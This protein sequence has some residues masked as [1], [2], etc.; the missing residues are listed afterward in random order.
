MQRLGTDPTTFGA[1]AAQL[2]ANG[3]SPVPIVPGWKYPPMAGWPKF[4]V[5]D[6]AL[7]EYR[8]YGCGLLCGELIGIDIDVLHEEASSELRGLAEPGI[9]PVRIGQP[10]KILVPYRTATPFRKKQTSKFVI[11]G[12]PARVEVPASGSSSSATRI[13]RLPRSPTAGCTA[14]HST[15]HLPLC[16]RSLE[17]EI[18]AFLA[19]AEAV[20]ALRRAGQ[21]DPR[22]WR[23]PRCV[24]HP[25][26]RWHGALTR[27]AALA[28]EVGQVATAA[29][30]G[31]NE[32]LNTAAMKLGRTGRGRLARPP[33]GRTLAWRC[34]PCERAGGG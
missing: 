22:Q 29:R 9:G 8:D 32:R 14:I 34:C 11:G 21:A 31:C 27:E 30:G 23:L 16:R 3:Y 1:V 18:K 26:F 7:S 2:V 5:D 24:S 28:D 20:L 4:R 10:P 13:T 33:P 6:T 12:H 17:V 25:P 15:F 19:K